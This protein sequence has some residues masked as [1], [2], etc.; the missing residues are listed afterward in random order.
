MILSRFY[1]FIGI[2][3]PTSFYVLISIY[4]DSVELKEMSVLISLLVS[5]AFGILVIAILGAIQLNQLRKERANYFDLRGNTFVKIKLILMFTFGV[6]YIFHCGL[7]IWKPF[8][9]YANKWIGIAS[10]VVG[11]LHIFLLLL[12]FAMFDKRD[13][14][15]YTCN[16]RCTDPSL[17]GKKKRCQNAISILAIFFSNFGSWIDALSTAC[18][19]K[20]HT[21][22]TQNV[23]RAIEV[24]E[25][26]KPLISSAII[27]F[28]LLTIDFLFPKTSMTFSESDL[29]TNDTPLRHSVNSNNFM[30]RC[31]KTMAQHI[32]FLASFGFFAFTFTEILI[33]D[34]SADLKA[35]VIT[36]ISIKTLNVLIILTLSIT[37]TIC[38]Y[39]KRS[40][41]SITMSHYNVWLF[42]L[43]FTCIGNISYHIACFFLSDS[44]HNENIKEIIYG[45]N[46]VSII[47]AVLQ[48]LFIIGNYLGN[49]NENWD[50]SSKSKNC[51][52]FTCSLLSMLNFGLMI[53]DSIG[54]EGLI[55]KPCDC[56]VGSILKTV[57]LLL[58][59]IFHFQ[60]S[61]EFLKLYRH[62][63][64][65]Y[66]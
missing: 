31:F 26:T 41:I 50:D 56:K 61:L 52:Y 60:T 36:Q 8:L 14:R 49:I 45:D 13:Y 7:Y 65:S 59:I 15:E 5:H 34:P 66:T 11:G 42:M 33:S 28:S 27:G 51:V 24:I 19:F 43:I 63:N 64:L 46:I 3:L 4:V 2:V 53:S 58:T 40:S 44:I 6:F 20:T 55:F 29:Q 1:F 35:Y 18:L 12:Y 48:T 23:T 62:K 54:K 39:G 17:E 22:P 47:L 32:F 10:Y 30:W 57:S 37:C 38:L 16:R 21:D 9:N 25:K